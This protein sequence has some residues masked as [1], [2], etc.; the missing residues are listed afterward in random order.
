M[1]LR[2]HQLV[3]LTTAGWRR[4]AT[5]FADG[6][7]QRCIAHWMAHDLPLVVA[8]QSAVPAVGLVALG[9]PA[10]RGWREGRLS[11]QIEA[12]ELRL[13]SAQFP[14]LAECAREPSNRSRRWASLLAALGP[15]ASAV[16]VY[17][18]FGWQRLTGLD[19]VS[20]RSDL[21]LLLPATDAR[22]ADAIV[23]SLLRCASDAP[24]LDGELC[25][26]DGSA[27]AWREWADWRSGRVRAILVK[28]LNGAR[29]ET[30]ASWLA[31]QPAIE[32]PA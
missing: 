16:R 3:R 5:A 17:G 18:S 28:R 20:A 27:V 14:T 30:N 4:A 25:F 24:R 32:L 22:H 7:A 29:L 21:D 19:H 9:L 13:D 6:D 2:R 23:E 31:A 8:T 26:S 1:K 12:T 11:P 10:P 15:S